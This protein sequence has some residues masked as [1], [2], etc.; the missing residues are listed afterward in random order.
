MSIFVYYT[1][2]FENKVSDPKGHIRNLISVTNTAFSNTKVPLKLSEFCIE[3]LD[4]EESSDT[5]QR[6]R[7]F[8]N[9]KGSLSNL[10]NTADIAILMTSKSVSY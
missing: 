6:M 8:W 9:A 5:N 10:L 2:Q 4:V 3:E 7:N 1:P